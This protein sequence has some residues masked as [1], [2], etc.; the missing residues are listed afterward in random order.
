MDKVCLDEFDIKKYVKD[1]LSEIKEEDEYIFAKSVLYDG[2]YRM[3]EVF[4]E[5]YKSL[6]KKVYDELERK[7]ESYEIAILLLSKNEPILK[8]VAW[9][10][11]IL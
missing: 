6:Y 3:S 9:K 7:E 10:T 4:E 8:K 11:K 5:R 2:L 1:R